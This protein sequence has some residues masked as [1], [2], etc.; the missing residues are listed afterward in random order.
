MTIRIVAAYKVVAHYCKRYKF[1][2]TKE[3]VRNNLSP[4]E[5][6]F[7]QFGTDQFWGK[8]KSSE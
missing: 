2:F 5:R 8:D 1:S 3:N 7:E 6:L 4:E